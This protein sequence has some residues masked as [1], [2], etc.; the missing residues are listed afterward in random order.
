MFLHFLALKV[1]GEKAL[2]VFLLCSLGGWDRKVTFI[3]EGDSYL[4]VYIYLE[5]EILVA[6]GDT[7][8]TPRLRK[9]RCFFIV[10]PALSSLQ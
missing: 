2:A 5:L 9:R 1:L 7:C 6:L 4:L 3:F 10:T 8:S